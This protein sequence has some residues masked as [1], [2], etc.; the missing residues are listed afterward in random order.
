MSIIFTNF[1]PSL[2]YQLPLLDEII[3]GVH[4]ASRPA[5][6]DRR[7]PLFKIKIQG[8]IL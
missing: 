6:E 2:R 7:P 1:T 3:T 4:L 5:L 8:D